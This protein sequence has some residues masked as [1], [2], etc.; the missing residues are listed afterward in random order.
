MPRDHSDNEH[1]LL[2]D[3]SF[4]R[5][6]NGKDTQEGASWEAWLRERPD[7]RRTVENARRSY[8]L[9]TAFDKRQPG[10]GSRE[11]VWEGI[12][13]RLQ[14]S[15]AGGAGNRWFPY[16]VSWLKYAAIVAGI[17]CILLGGERLLSGR[18]T[19]V[20]SSSSIK[21]VQLPDG[22][23]AVLNINSRLSYPSDLGSREVREVWVEGKAF[24][25]VSP[26]SGEDGLQAPFIVHL[27]AMDIQVLGTA[28]N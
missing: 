28:F 14:A 11:E 6:L 22:S 5:W 18:K 26:K 8:R 2:S 19:V 17:V 4:L 10:D 23:R 24:L 3:D 1:D 27:G 15:P 20:T 16:P 13:E 21:E 12:R 9:L 25:E 7:K